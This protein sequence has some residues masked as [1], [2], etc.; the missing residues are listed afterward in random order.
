MRSPPSSN[1]TDGRA[2]TVPKRKGCWLRRLSRVDGG[3][4]GR[5]TL[6]RG[7]PRQWRRRWS[8]RRQ[9]PGSRRATVRS[10][11]APTT[12]PLLPGVGE[13]PPNPTKRA[14]RTTTG[15]QQPRCSPGV[16]GSGSRV[17][18]E[19]Q[20]RRKGLSPAQVKW[21]RSP[22]KMKETPYRHDGTDEKI[23]DWL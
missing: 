11:E 2:V 9:C 13:R 12:L 5:V 3:A 16:L 22:W 7:P 6:N 4:R 21:L 20:C 18:G 10:S 23:A 1:A 17:A 15:Q 8:D 19:V 14:A